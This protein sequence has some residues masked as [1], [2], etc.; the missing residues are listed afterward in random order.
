MKNYYKNKM[1]A[2]CLSIVLA[3]AVSAVEKTKPSVKTK[4]ESQD[5]IPKQNQKRH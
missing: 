3:S 4:K 2:L 1:R 5:S